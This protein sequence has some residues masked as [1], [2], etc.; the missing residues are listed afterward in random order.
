VR[1]AQV[2]FLSADIPDTLILTRIGS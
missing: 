2:A 1:P